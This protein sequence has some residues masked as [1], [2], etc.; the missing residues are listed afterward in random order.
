MCNRAMVLAYT[1]RSGADKQEEQK[2]GSDRIQSRV[3]SFFP[4]FR[5]GGGKVLVK[6]TTYY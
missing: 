4:D 2:M 6:A 1:V 3:S 5:L